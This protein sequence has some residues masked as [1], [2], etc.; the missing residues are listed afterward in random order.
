MFVS[1]PS[2]CRPVVAGRMVSPDG[3]VT[4]SFQNTFPPPVSSPSVVSAG[5]AP[6]QCLPPGHLQGN[7]SQ[8]FRLL[9]FIMSKL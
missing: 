6:L 4:V 7:V 9:C 3:V 8:H 2:I 5:V 1:Q